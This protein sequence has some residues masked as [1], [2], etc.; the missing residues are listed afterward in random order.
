MESE[1][2]V[3][4]NGSLPLWPLSR[5]FR[6]LVAVF[7]AVTWFGRRRG[8]VFHHLAICQFTKQFQSQRHYFSLPLECQR[9]LYP[10]I[11]MEVLDDGR[12]EKE[13]E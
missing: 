2:D 4:I 8:L 7:L 12:G 11:Y 3:F 9:F 13:V 1:E 10:Q 5:N 6:I